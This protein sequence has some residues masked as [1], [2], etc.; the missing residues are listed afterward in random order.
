MRP[1]DLFMKVL[2]TTAALIFST[3]PM[4]AQAGES[5]ISH[6]DQAPITVENDSVVPQRKEIPPA[7][8]Q[9]PQTPTKPSAYVPYAAA[10]LPP[11]NTAANAPPSLLNRRKE[12]IASMALIVRITAASLA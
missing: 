5:G 1:E 6:P 10:P 11:A 12:T 4:L 2:L 9:Q 3:V 7:A 8:A